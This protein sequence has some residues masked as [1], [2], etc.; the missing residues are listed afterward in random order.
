MTQGKYNYEMNMLKV[1]AAVSLY[2]YRS[3]GR[4]MY[5]NFAM[6]DTREALRLYRNFKEAKK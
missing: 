3:T 1:N 6:A 5:L 4:F 2:N